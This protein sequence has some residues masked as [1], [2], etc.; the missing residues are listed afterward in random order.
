MVLLSLPTWA[1]ARPP[2]FPLAL[3]AAFSSAFSDGLRGVMG[4]RGS[5]TQKISKLTMEKQALYFLVT[6]T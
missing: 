3:T 4:V 6:V 1:Q 5:D 2:P